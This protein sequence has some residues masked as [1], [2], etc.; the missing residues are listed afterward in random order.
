MIERE[1]LTI[2]WTRK[3][4][5]A[6][7]QCV[8]A[9]FLIG[10][11]YMTCFQQAEAIALL[12]LSLAFCGFQFPSVFVNHGDI[13]PNYAGTIFGI[14]NTGASIPGIIAP[15]VVASITVNKSQKEWLVAF[16]I[17][18]VIYV[19]GV[20]FFLIFSDGEIQEW[21]KDDEILEMVETDKPEANKLPGLEEDPEEDV[22]S[23]DVVFK[24]DVEEN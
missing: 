10:L 4:F 7:G 16:Y 19:L 1:I 15:Y 14:T 13:A 2:K 3:L 22:L 9:A 17:A 5:C 21:A 6:I 12:T 20:I 24:N 8:P 18:A 11:G 23:D